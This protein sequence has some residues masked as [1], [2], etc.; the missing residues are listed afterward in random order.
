[1]TPPMRPH[2]LRYQVLDPNRGNPVHEIS[3]DA[4]PDEI[5][6]LVEEGYFVRSDWFTQDQ[7]AAMRR[8][9]DRI[10]AEEGDRSAVDPSS[11]CGG[12]R[13]L[14]FLMDK[15]P[16]F[17]NLL[18]F[19][20]ALSV[21]QAVLGPLIRFDQVDGRYWVPDAKRQHVGWHIH[22]RGVSVPMPPFFSY[23]HAVH[24]L[25]YLDD[26]DERNG[27]LCVLPRSHRRVTD[28]YQQG[29]SSDLPGQQI[30]NVAAGDCVIIHG[31]LWHR[32]LP[33]TDRSLPRRLLVFGYMSAWMIGDEE[34]GLKPPYRPTE[35]LRI[36]G[37]ARTRALLG[38]F[39]WG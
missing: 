21:A 15:D 1:M 2:V 7:I 24:M 6:S 37:D 14:R 11:N 31:N 12:A 29:D 27:P 5:E 38:E 32:S 30:I 4:T 39:H 8:A 3:V 22:L 34:G 36:R 20:P 13:Y 16:A 19:E 10:A 23:P 28:I 18:Y 33:H 35:E 25:L 9:L 17:L 26:V